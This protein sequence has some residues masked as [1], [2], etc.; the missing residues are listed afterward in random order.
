MYKLLCCLGLMLTLVSCGTLNGGPYTVLIASAQPNATAEVNGH[1]YTLPADVEVKREKDTLRIKLVTDSL[2][3]DYFV[4][5][6]LSPNAIAGNMFFTAMY[7]VALLVDLGT[8]KGYYYGKYIYLDA[9]NPEPVVKPWWGKPIYKAKPVEQGR[10]NVMISM[11]YINNFYQQPK[12]RH[13]QSS[14]GFFGI[15]A[16]FEYY[17]AQNRSVKAAVLA[18]INFPVFVPAPVTDISE[19]MYSI[20]FSVTQNYQLGRLQLGYG[21]AFISNG[22]SWRRGENIEESLDPADPNKSHEELINRSLGLSLTAY[23]RLGKSFHLGVVYNP[24]IYS[25]KPEGEFNYEHALML[26]LLW[27]IKLFE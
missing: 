19:R 1:T 22:W 24:S 6:R 3:K 11:P 15:G 14:T 7:P 21:P 2:Q 13:E 17:Y 18:A 20:S 16:G 27:K 4:K 8:H 23:Y 25:I 5:A 10:M 9:N 26:D 12:N